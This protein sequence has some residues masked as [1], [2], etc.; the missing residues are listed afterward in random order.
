MKIIDTT[1]YTYFIAEGAPLKGMDSAYGSGAGPI[2]L[3]NVVCNG[4]EDNLLLCA[5]NDLFVNNC[6]HSEDAAVV[7]DGKRTVT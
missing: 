3:D 2:I 4:S 6:D 5:H 1:G 7:C